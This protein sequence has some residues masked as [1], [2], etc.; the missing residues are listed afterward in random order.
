MRGSSF[1]VVL[2]LAILWYSCG[3]SKKVPK[4]KEVIEEKVVIANDSLEYEI[5]ILDQGFTTYLNSIAK[6]KWYY[7]ESYYKTK[8]IFYVQEWNIRVRNSIMN[9]TSVFENEIN[10]DSKINYGLEVEYL[11][12]SYFKFV[13]YKYKVKF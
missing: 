12:F 3:S 7:S 8:N 6:P 5:I 10:Y 4:N 13:E 1:L 2:F 11:L 9:R